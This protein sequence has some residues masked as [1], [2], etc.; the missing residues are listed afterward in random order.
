MSNFFARASYEAKRICVKPGEK[1][2][3]GVTQKPGKPS[4]GWLRVGH[5]DTAR[6]YKLPV[7]S[8]ELHKTVAKILDSIT[9]QVDAGQYACFFWAKEKNGILWVDE[10]EEDRRDAEQ[11]KIL[12]EHRG[13]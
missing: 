5:G 1:F 2:Q 13:Y 7:E 4:H 9:K 11:E 10:G 6:F 12:C 3:A 8:G